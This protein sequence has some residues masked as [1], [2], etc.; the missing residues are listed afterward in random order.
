M[1]RYRLLMVVTAV[2]V[3]VTYGL[4]VR[5]GLTGNKAPEPV[6]SEWINKDP[7]ALMNMKGKVVV[8]DFFQMWCP[9]CNNFSVPLMFQLEEKY[10]KR[11]DIV[12]ISIH[13]VFEGHAYQTPADLKE[14]VIEKGI[15]HPVGIDEYDTDQ[16]VPITMRKYRTGGTP[17]ITIIDKNGYVRFQK[18][19]GFD[20]DSAFKV[21]DQLLGV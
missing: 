2:V 9:G 18:L 4:P 8:I 3:A 5:A 16:Y 13:T 21:I 15:K 6:V 12:F 7:G 17:C 20:P 11:N 19:G 1:K 14:Y 10:K